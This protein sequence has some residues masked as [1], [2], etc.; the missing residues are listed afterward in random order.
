MP[1][2]LIKKPSSVTGCQPVGLTHTSVVQ[3][4]ESGTELLRSNQLQ[5]LFRSVALKYRFVG[6]E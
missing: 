3:L 5:V 6:P 1:Q 4:G 2:R